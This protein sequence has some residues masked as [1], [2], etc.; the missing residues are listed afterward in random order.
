MKSGRLC[1]RSKLPRII[2]FPDAEEGRA[3]EKNG[4]Q[5]ISLSGMPVNHRIRFSAVIRTGRGDYSNSYRDFRIISR[6]EGGEEGR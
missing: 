6:G 4:R 3:A 2:L 1:Q 5:T